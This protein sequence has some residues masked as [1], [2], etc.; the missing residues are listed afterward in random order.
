MVVVVGFA[1]GYNSLN[2]TV[3]DDSI[4][5]SSSPTYR[6]I[7]AGGDG[8]D[9]LN[10]GDGDDILYGG[11]G[12]DT[13][14]GGY[15][16][17]IVSGGPGVDTLTGGPGRDTFLFSDDPFSG[18]T[19]TPANNGISVLNQPDV[20]TD[21]QFGEDKL[22]FDSQKFGIRTL[23]FQQGNSAQL[24]GDHNLLVLLDPFPNAAAAAKAIADNDAITAKNG[25]FV[26]FNL[27]LGFSRVVYSQDLSNGGSISVLG[28]LTNQTD[29]AN[30]AL[31]SAQNFDLSNVINQT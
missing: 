30:Q 2:R 8:D 26:Y 12:N 11:Y 13:I 9:T 14:N 27:N 3:S 10:G 20:L 19:P 23:T 1:E 15:G 29:V 31:F 7:V 6:V 25:L 18:G 22:Q 17:D 4:F 24:F 16:N 5:P 28:N 21:F